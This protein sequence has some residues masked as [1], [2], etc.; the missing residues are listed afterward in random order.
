MLYFEDEDSDQDLLNILLTDDYLTELPGEVSGELPDILRDAGFSVTEKEGEDLTV[1]VR[2]LSGLGVVSKKRVPSAM[3]ALGTLNEP[4]F[5]RGLMNCIFHTKRE[6][7]EDLGS[8][9]FSWFDPDI[10]CYLETDNRINGFLLIHR[11]PSGSLRVEFLSAYGPDARTDLMFMIRFS[12]LQAMKLCSEDIKVILRRHDEVARNLTGYLFPG[13]KG[14]PCLY[15]E[16][17]EGQ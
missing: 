8:L 7:V 17:A 12:I 13:K 11:L 5:R 4:L 15:G 10:S 14:E 16:R 1:T 9:P 3:R 6:V 2:D